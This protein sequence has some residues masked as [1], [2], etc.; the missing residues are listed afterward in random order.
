MTGGLT[1]SSA[2]GQ[3]VSVYL[4]VPPRQPTAAPPQLPFTGAPIDGAVAVAGALL[5]AGAAV[6]LAA[7]GPRS[8][9]G[10]E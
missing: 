10:T 1:V 6:L 5:L 7:R 3:Q 4:V 8:R 2:S 9:R